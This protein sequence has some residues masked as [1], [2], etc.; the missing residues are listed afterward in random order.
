MSVCTNA[1]TEVFGKTIRRLPCEAV[2][3][4]TLATADKSS[5]PRRADTAGGIAEQ[6]DDSLAERKQAKPAGI[7]VDLLTKVLLRYS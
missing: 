1:A 7:F 6:C 3:R 5:P 4:N 2:R